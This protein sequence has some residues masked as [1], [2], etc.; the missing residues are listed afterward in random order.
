MTTSSRASDRIWRL[1]LAVILAIAACL[2]LYQLG[3]PTMWWDEILVPL[4]ARFPIPY[5]LDFSRHCEMHPPLYHLF[6]KV[7]ELTGLSDFALRLPSAVCGLGAV[8]A[9]WRLFSRLYDRSVGLVAA[10]FLAGS[11]MQVWHVRQVRPYAI[12]TV[13]FIFSLYF[14]L[15]FLR[16][17]KNRDLWALLGVNAVLLCLHYFMFQV[18]FAQGVVLLANWRPR[19]QGIRLGQLGIFACGTA[20]IA[21]PVLVFFF[22]PSQTTLS[23]FAD[24][25]SFAAIGRLIAT[26]AAD[27]LWS[28][29]DSAMR[30]VLGGVVTL[31]VMAMA[32][33][34]PRELG[35][36]LL[37]VAI[38]ALILFCMRKTAYF[39]PRHFLYM[40]VVAALFAGQATRL[41]P[42]PGLAV[43]V[44]L[45]LTILPAA[46]ILWAH[47]EAYY[48]PT[49]YHHPVFVTDF[50]PM[51]REL[52]GRLHPGQVIAASDPGTANAV[53][54]Y[55][56]RF[57]ADNPFRDQHLAATAPD[58][59]LLFFAPFKNWGHLGKT[60][61]AFA[62]AVGPIAHT[63]QVL[64]ARLYTLPVHREKAPVL[65]AM[66]FHLR[67]RA[68]FPDF[69][70]QVGAFSDM[71]VN[72]Y[73][74]G[75]A[76]PTRNS[77]PAFLEYRIDNAAGDAPQLLQWVIEYKNEGR[78]STMAFSA[79]FD[80]E[81]AVPLFTST[82]PDRQGGRTVSLVRQ[83]P[84]KTLTL[85][86]DTVCAPYTARYPGGNLET[87]AFRGFDLE[88][89]PLG[90]FDSP[91]PFPVKE[92]GLGRIE[93]NADNLWRWGLGPQST[94][95]FELAQAGTYLLDLDYAN[96]IP[97]QTVTIAANGKV[98]A[99][100]ADLPADARDSR[101][102]AIP[103][104][105][106]GNTV[107]IAYSDWNH[108]KTT[109]AATDVRPMALFIRRLRLLPGN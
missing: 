43:P 103:G 91:V 78:A 12:L 95:R 11:A 71:T 27:V 88:V 73:W 96:G 98:L 54:W 23:I 1:A 45:L 75:E 93:H 19:S 97:G 35:A 68:A 55:L 70:R 30:L 29:D 56:D 37:V 67:R 4:T 32:R 83:K 53:S 7:V 77:R 94:L 31:G 102:I 108:G 81:P 16:E 65:T 64:N 101:R 25:A 10:A 38:P 41:L 40:T 42:R 26:Y 33:R 18:V 48:L 24:K 69:Y 2:R 76:I 85:R 21:L 34:A 14:L 87:T 59:S 36:C 66:P 49:S 58:Y 61:E 28:H 8:Y 9:V 47:P 90:H 39:S 57:V 100:L 63:E 99:I 89:V 62:A 60:E 107:V 3:T 82:G 86:L 72:P 106:G 46:N 13:L 84:Y 74:G 5:I 50:K 92:E 52:A 15:R 79:R 6:V 104:R 17:R 51:A 105:K 109:F 44:S 20:G 80:D 22:L